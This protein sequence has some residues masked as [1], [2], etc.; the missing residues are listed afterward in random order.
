MTSQA[1][2]TDSANFTG[3]NWVDLTDGGN[4]TLHVHSIYYKADGT[5]P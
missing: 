1:R 4:T 5:S 2:I 3:T